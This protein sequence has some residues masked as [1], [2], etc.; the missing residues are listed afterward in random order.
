MRIELSSFDV[1]IGIDW[2]SKYH[3]VIIHDER[4]VRIPY[5][6]EVL[7]IKGDGSSGISEKKA[8]DKS[9]EKHL[10][11]NLIARDF[12]KVFLEDLSG[13]PPTREFEFQIDLVLGATPV[14]RAAYRLASLEMPELS[15]Q[16]QELADKGFIRLSSSPLEALNRYPL[17]TIN[18]VYDQLQGSSVYLKIDLR[19]G[20]HLLRVREED[21]PKTA[22]RT[23]YVHYEF[24]V[25][26]FGL[27]NT[28]TIFMELMN[29]KVQFL[30]HVIDSEGIY[31][32]PT[33]IESINDWA[34]PK[35]PMEIHQF[36]G[37]AGYYRRFNKGFSKINKPITKLTQK[38]VKFDWG[39]KE[40]IAFQLLKQKMC[41][42]LIL[43]LPERSEN[44]VVY[45]DALHKG[46]GAILMQKEKV[47]ACASCQL[48][49]HEKSYM[50]YDLE[51][52]SRHG[53]SVSIISD[54]DSRF[55]SHFWQS[56]QKALDTQQDMS[57]AYHLQ[58][59][60]Q[61]K[62][63]IQTL[64]DMLHQKPIQAA[65]DHQKSYA[66]VR[67]KPLEFQIREGVMLKVSPWKGVIHEIKIDDKLHF[68]EEPV[69]IMDREVKRL[70]HSR[71]PIVKVRWNSRRGLKFTWECKYQCLAVDN[72]DVLCG[73]SW[74][75]GVG[76]TDL[77][78]DHMGWLSG[79][80]TVM[81]GKSGGVSNFVSD[82]SILDVTMK[83]SSMN[84]FLV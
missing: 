57:T 32:D 67:R 48:K 70:K 74:E 60:G 28:P 20:Y 33:K 79:S 10:E 40:E 13:L 17:S 35:I 50:T 55:T 27:T 42:V 80:I 46:L 23:C 16:L 82:M 39:E 76:A 64:E 4:I 61:I 68:I 77:V 12:L 65:R 38:S 30:I 49:T 78:L 37:L 47:I 81:G 53:V 44:F 3:A 19:S 21:T 26:P 59:D 8:E 62:R 83:S 41:S 63:T 52:V 31:V 1:I 58:T 15:T 75:V 9:K 34:S 5:G 69:K 45:Y 6:D 11:D 51:L 2:L 66:D 71:V 24:Q 22:F 43:A 73:V 36:L 14:A 18:D 54:R 56:L 7:M 25:M 84:G 29:R 72:F